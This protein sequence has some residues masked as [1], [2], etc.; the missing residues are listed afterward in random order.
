VLCNS[1]TIFVHVHVVY[2]RMLTSINSLVS[3]RQLLRKFEA[4]SKEQ[5]GETRERRTTSLD[6]SN[7]TSN[8]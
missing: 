1:L 5:I 3:L 8:I 4:I 6:A 7:A 2:V